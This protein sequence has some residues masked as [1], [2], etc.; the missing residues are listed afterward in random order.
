[1]TRYFIEV[2]YLGTNY[3]G[4]QIQKNAI[5]IQSEVE[6]ALN[7]FLHKKINLTGSS[8]TDAGVNALSNF[9]H[10]DTELFIG[11]QHLYNLNSLLPKDIVVKKI[12]SVASNAHARFDALSRQYK[13]YISQHKNPFLNETSYFYPY[14]L[15]IMQMQEAANIIIGISDFTSFSKKKT[16]VKTNICKIIHSQW[17]HDFD[18]NC[19]VYTVEA[20]RFLR[21]MVKALVSTML[22]VGRK[23]L[24]LHDFTE[25][26]ESRNSAKANFSA[27]SKGLFLCKVLYSNVI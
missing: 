3:S 5:S 15:D 11:D 1:M 23:R 26:I 7:I 21:G 12:F 14:K 9:F 20:N 16:Q 17:S 24:S 4:F 2:A 10:F 27:P 22:L 25:I 13:Y 18:K 6:N 8:R 19:I